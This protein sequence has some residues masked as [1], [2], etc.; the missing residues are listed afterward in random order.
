MSKFSAP[1]VSVGSSADYVY[2]ILP[3]RQQAAIRDAWLE[4]RLE[5]IMPEIMR[6]HKLDAWLII[7]REYN[8]DPL[9][10]S[11][12]PATMLSA[13]RL[14]M[15]AFFLS[16]DDTLEKL[17]VSRY[18]IPPFYISAWDPQ[19]EGQWDAL[20]R[21]IRER[22]PQRI[23]INVGDDFALGDGLSHSLYQQLVQALGPD[24]SQRLC[25]AELASIAWL[26]RRSEPEIAAYK[27]IVQI[28]HALV[29]EAFSN[30]VIHPGVTS[31]E[32]VVWWLRQ[33]THDLGL[34]CWFQPSVS[35]QRQGQKQLLA[36]TTI[37]PGDLLHCDFGL[38]YLGLATDTQQQAYVLKVDESD[39]PAGLHA[40]F[41]TANKLQDILAEAMQVGRT[42]N[43]ILRQALTTAAAAGI[44]ASI[45]TH[46]IG[47]H[48]HGAGPTIGLWDAQEGVP[49]RGDY[50][51]Y[52]DTCHAMELNIVQAVPEWEGQEVRI[53][54]EQD[55]LMHEGRVIFLAG[56][57][58][59]LHLI[60]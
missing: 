18:N 8:E 10:P 2:K 3:L 55:V 38:H 46:P 33:R 42:G 47:Y 15:L 60:D 43:E 32:D 39:A 19:H 40:A 22:D 44:K 56:R 20:A 52:N 14:T 16:P 28:A 17:T 24:L 12:L 27:G 25:S 5:V 36:T 7:G 41:A 13:R 23:G 29:Q 49:G 31:P 53:A 48:G 37:M 1:L 4:H 9:L 45:Y 34:T 59:K 11:F 6:R 51:L 26:E 58:T 21:L 35:I 57:Q 30:R 54:L 50:P